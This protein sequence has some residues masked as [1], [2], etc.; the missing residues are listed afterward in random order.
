MRYA[1]K[2]SGTQ[3]FFIGFGM[4]PTYTPVWGSQQQARVWGN[5]RDAHAQALCFSMNGVCAQKTPVAV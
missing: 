1:I 4:A 2:K 3:E 5:S